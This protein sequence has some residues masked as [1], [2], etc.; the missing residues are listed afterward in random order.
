MLGKV[1]NASLDHEKVL[2]TIQLLNHR[3][4]ERFP[5]SGLSKV[6]DDLFLIAG[7]ALKNLEWIGKPQVVLRVISYFIIFLA[8]CGIILS[9]SL[10][11][12]SEENFSFTDI[13]TFLEAAI[14]DIVLLG[15][16]VFFM[17]TLENRIK[18]SKAIKTLNELRAIAHV[19]DMHQLT[20]DPHRMLKS[21]ENTEHSPKQTLSK[22]Q[23]QRYLDYCS[24]MQSLIGKVAAL[25]SQHL[26]D[27]IVVS[28]VNEIENLT[29]GFSRKVWQ[30]LIML[31]EIK[32]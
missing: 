14:N 13:V 26:P 30:K 24:E 7:R 2:K 20:K 4:S 12:F 29:T 28:S 6:G 22:L 3:V 25:Y 18:R 11:D 27:D 1:Q 32:D 17:V 9:L 23:L 31:N 15:A 21:K 19:V 16:A 8:A 10:V 5:D